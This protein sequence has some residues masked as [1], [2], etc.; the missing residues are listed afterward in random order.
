MYGQGCQPTGSSRIWFKNVEPLYA[1]HQTTLHNPEGHFQFSSQPQVSLFRE[2][3]G[4]TNKP[5]NKAKEQTTDV[6]I[7]YPQYTGT[8]CVYNCALMVCTVQDTTVPHDQNANPLRKQAYAT[9]PPPAAQVL[10]HHVRN[11]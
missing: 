8:G 6:L 2:Y 7:K 1:C 3:P 9:N 11:A 5:T 10:E 4:K